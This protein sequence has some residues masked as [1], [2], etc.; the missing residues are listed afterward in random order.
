[1]L[2]LFLPS[3]VTPNPSQPNFSKGQSTLPSFPQSSIHEHPPS[4]QYFLDNTPAQILNN[5]LIAK[6][7]GHFIGSSE[8]SGQLLLEIPLPPLLCSHLILDLFLYPWPG[9]LSLPCRSSYSTSHLNC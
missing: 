9:N 6:C 5:L 2:H 4:F 7:R 8:V 3:H 1:M